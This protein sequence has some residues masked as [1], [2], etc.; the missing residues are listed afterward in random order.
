[1]LLAGG[2]AFLKLPWLVHSRSPQ[3]GLQRSNI[4]DLKMVREHTP[5][6]PENTEIHSGSR[7][8]EV[9]DHDNIS[10]DRPLPQVLQKCPSVPVFGWYL[11]WLVHAWGQLRQVPQEADRQ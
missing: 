8:Q 6:H 2:Q 5:A 3:A 11:A 7:T 10:S 4:C 9:L 1:M